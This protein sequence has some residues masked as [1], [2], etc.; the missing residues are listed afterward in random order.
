MNVDIFLDNFT[1]IV[2]I[3][4]FHNISHNCKLFKKLMIVAVEMFII[5]F[6]SHKFIAY[7]VMVL[8]I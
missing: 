4:V 7:F 2:N 6:I 8:H 5:C 1:E 3:G